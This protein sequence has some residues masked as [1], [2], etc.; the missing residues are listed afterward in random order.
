ME[1]EDIAT[2]KLDLTG[3]CLNLRDGN[4][5]GRVSPGSHLVIRTQTLACSWKPA[6]TN[7]IHADRYWL[8][9][10]GFQNQVI[11]DV[12]FKLDSQRWNNWDKDAVADA[13]IALVGLT[14]NGHTR[15]LVLHRFPNAKSYRRIGLLLSPKDFMFDETCAWLAQAFEE[16]GLTQTI[17]LE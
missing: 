11:G 7:C 14:E 16:G 3:T 15:A 12:C 4:P 8:Q 17:A 2:P 6:P 1:S 5:F 10:L 9:V 13:V